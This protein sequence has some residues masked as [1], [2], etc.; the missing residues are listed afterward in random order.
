M[1]NQLHSTKLEMCVLNHSIF[2]PSAVHW[3]LNMESAWQKFVN[4]VNKSMNSIS[5]I[6]DDEKSYVQNL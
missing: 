3:I 5:Y 4:W 1:Y 6:F 2:T